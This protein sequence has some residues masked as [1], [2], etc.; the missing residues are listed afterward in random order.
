[1]LTKI[2]NEKGLLLPDLIASLPL[3]LIVVLV[4]VLS[5]VNYITAYSDIR[6]YTKLQD[7]LFQAVETIRYGYVERGINTDGQSLCGLLSANQVRIGDNRNRLNLEVHTGTAYTVGTSVWFSDGEMY[8]TGQYG[9]SSFSSPTDNS[10][11]VRIF[12]ETTSEIDHE[13]KYKIV[14]SGSSFSSLGEDSEGNIRLLG[15]KLKAQ[16]RFRERKNG[17]SM[18]DDIL[19]NTRTIQYETKV[20]IGN[21][22]QQLET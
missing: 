13:P 3:G 8:L 1:M 21:T 16:V 12:P 22:P 19:M 14:E 5:I 7:D 10:R 15:I 9:A 20:F 18:N 4:M 2:Q 11:N 17:Q 6:D